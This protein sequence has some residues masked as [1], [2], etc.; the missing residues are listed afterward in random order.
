MFAL[1]DLYTVHALAIPYYTGMVIRKSNGGLAGLHAAQLREYPEAFARLAAFKEGI[2]SPGLA[3]G[4][5]ALYA[6]ATLAILYICFSARRLSGS[7]SNAA[8]M[9]TKKPRSGSPRSAA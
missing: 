4:L 7:A 8:A 5:W 1:L 9:R 6:A 3:A 2:V